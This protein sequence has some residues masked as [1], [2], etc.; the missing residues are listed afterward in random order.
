[1]FDNQPVN[2]RFS[3]PGV[4][5]VGVVQVANDNETLLN[6]FSTGPNVI[7]DI[8]NDPD[9]AAGD[10]YTIALWNGGKDTGKRWFSGGISPL[11]AGRIR[12]SPVKL[13]GGQ[14]QIRITQTAGV[15]AIHNVVMQFARGM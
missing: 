10:A 12:P 3:T 4:G 6:F 9:P 15:A 8:V 2:K 14:Y 7:L 1:M 11:T 13:A 5:V